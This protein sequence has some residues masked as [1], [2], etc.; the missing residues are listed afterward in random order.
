MR[1]GDSLAG[2]WSCGGAVVLRGSLAQA[3]FG[4][5]SGRRREGGQRERHFGPPGLWAFGLL[6]IW[7]ASDMA[8]TSAGTAPAKEGVSRRRRGERRSA[9][10]TVLG[11]A[12]LRV[13]GIGFPRVCGEE[14]YDVVSAIHKFITRTH[15]YHLVSWHSVPALKLHSLSVAQSFCHLATCLPV[16]HTHLPP[17]LPPSLLLP[18]HHHFHRH[19]HH[20]RTKLETLSFRRPER[21]LLSG[22]ISGT[23]QRRRIGTLGPGVMFDEDGR[24]NI[25]ILWWQG[26]RAC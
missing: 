22:T 26:E 6:G 24:Q 20:H 18:T 23:G 13:L 2:E 4:F 3:P 8:R 5:P 1:C 16:T 7:C 15:M 21:I 11:H 14:A 10:R 9:G 25:G 12:E 17:S 19:H